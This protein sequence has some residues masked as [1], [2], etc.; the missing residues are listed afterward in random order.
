MIVPSLSRLGPT[1]M[2]AVACLGA[3]FPATA[4]APLVLA[5]TFVEGQ[6][7][8]VTTASK[9][10]PACVVTFTALNDE[11]RDP[12]VVGIF[13]NRAVQSPPDTQAWL[14]S[15]VGGLSRR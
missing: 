9:D 1:A 8:V 3:A 7:N 13:N 10:A 15:I 2:A 14:R 5:S 6:G 12:T 11:R 4:K